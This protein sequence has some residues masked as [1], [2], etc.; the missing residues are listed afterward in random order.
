M[1][2]EFQS[3]AHLH[4]LGE[5]PQGAGRGCK[6]AKAATTPLSATH[7]SVRFLGLQHFAFGLLLCGAGFHK[8]IRHCGL[9]EEETIPT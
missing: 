2:I 5:Y 9:T 8:I 6:A 4:Q 7:S 3:H 1:S